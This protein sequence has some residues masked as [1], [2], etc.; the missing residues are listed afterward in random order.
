MCLLLTGHACAAPG[1]DITPLLTFEVPAA[2][3]A[4]AGWSGGPS[5]TLFLDTT[6]IHGGT[7]SGR[8][9]RTATSQNAFSTFTTSLPVDFAGKSIE[10]RG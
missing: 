7:R 8:L 2:D 5:G 6:T 4:P 9:E 3:E 10:L 1:P